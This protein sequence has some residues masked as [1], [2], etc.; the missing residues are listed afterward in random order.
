MRARREDPRT[1]RDGRKGLLTAILLALFD[2]LAIP[3]YAQDAICARVRIEIK[4]E[5][6]LE[7]QAFE[8]EMQITN[9]VDT[10]PMSEVTI[11]VLF[12]D[13]NGN[14]VKAT[15]E[16]NDPSGKALFFIRTD[17]LEG[18]QNITGTGSIG[19]GATAKIR[20]LIIPAAGSGG[21]STTG[22]LYLVGAV[23]GYKLG[24]EPKTI[25]VAPDSIFVKPLPKLALDYFLTNEVYADDPFTPAI[26]PPEPFTLGV[27]VKNNGTV[28]ARNLKIESAQPKI[29]E[30]TQGLLINFRLTGSYVNDQ[31]A[32]N[33]LLIGFG[34][35]P[36][37]RA[38][39]GRWIMITTLSGKF[40]DFSATFTH[41][42]ELGGSV[43]SLLEPPMTHLL[44][45]D[46]KVDL[47]GRDGV[48]DFL[49]RD[50]DALN[51]Y[52]SDSGDSPVIDQSGL[53]SLAQGATQ[54]A[55]TALQLNAPATQGFFYAKLKDPFSG[56]K[57][58]G[59]VVRADGKAMAPENVWLSK[60]RN[61]S[62]QWEYFVNF[63]DV[64]T[65]GRYNLVMSPRPSGPQPPVLQFLADYSVREGQ[66]VSFVVEASDPNGDQVKLSAAPLPAGAKFTDGGA[67]TG[68]FD[69]I[70][71]PGQAGKYT[72]VYEASDGTLKS[73]QSAAI[74]VQPAKPNGPDIPTLA[75]PAVDSDVRV[76]RPILVV[77]SS[78]PLDT[79]Q[80][81]TF[82]VYGDGGLS[83]LLYQADVAKAGDST[84]W[85]VPLDLTD[86]T[87]YWW[88]V[89]AFDGT[90]YSEWAV[91]RFFVNLANDPPA[92][93]QPSYPR[94]GTQVDSLTPTF[95]VSNSADPDGDAVTFGFQLYADNA[96][97]QSL[98]SVKD[99][100]AG[101]DGTTSW[102]PSAPLT[103]GRDYF[104][105]ATAT[106]VHG[107]LTETPLLKFSVNTANHA[108][109]APVVSDPPA[110]STLPGA[111][112]TL[113]VANATDADGDLLSYSLELDTTPSFNGAAKRTS[114][115]LNSGSGTTSWNVTGLSDDT[116]YY[117]RARA[118]DGKAD[119]PW[120]RGEFLVS[121]RDDPPPVPVLRNVG[122]G[123]CTDSPRPRLELAPV[124]DPEGRPVTYRFQLYGDAAL[125]ALIAEAD[126]VAPEWL[127]PVDLA[128][129]STYYWRARAKDE[130]GN[131][132]A[133]TSAAEFKVILAGVPAPSITL[134]SPAQIVEPKDGK[135]TIGWEIRDA[136][137]SSAVALYWDRTG[138]G[139][140]GSLIVDKLA[141]D[142]A[143]RAGQY[144]WDVSTFAPGVYY[145]Y[146]V[147]NNPQRMSV[148]YAA[149]I[150][151][152][153]SPAPKG[154]VL[155]KP[156]SAQTTTET[157]ATATVQVVLGSEPSADVVVGVNSSRPGEGRVN[158][159]SL[160]FTQSNWS[161]P[162]TV[163]I[164][165]VNDCIADGDQAYRIIAARAV[166]NDLNYAGVKGPDQ[167]LINLDDDAPGSSTQFAVCNIRLV[168]TKR[169]S[170]LEFDYSFLLDATNL[171]AD[172]AGLTGTL[173]VNATGTKV[174]DGNVVFGP[175]PSGATVTSQ[176]TFTIRQDR[177]YMFDPKLLQWTLT[178]VP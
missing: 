13:E 8:A 1:T 130:G 171:G 107:A 18:I 37:Q 54:G 118:S 64:N 141:Q 104:W 132:S 103:Q 75:G 56:Q 14:P 22:K 136:L 158:P 116:R 94:N 49:A 17:G 11:N 122:A 12:S 117:W 15:S 51:V 128:D 129:G 85:K 52:E 38:S 9:A 140:S 142:P 29:T 160:T 137:N 33:S 134:T 25:E 124:W 111:V 93:P 47:P 155:I 88:R 16:P 55:D 153:V 48:R 26:E 168:A 78:N 74:T 114:A 139:A 138:S 108:P 154:T 145:V 84:T 23:L 31:P 65:P 135:V 156:T 175:I 97:T 39:M 170:T 96:G 105:R 159:A 58:V 68:V 76:L 148:Q 113:T 46:V 163:V 21:A 43:T 99:L 6:T 61:S 151:V 146:A 161:V 80:R 102:T 152:I 144:V 81:Y 87:R 7:R 91:G 36:A 10:N 127:V 121:A 109:G 83:T 115:P 162:Q 125:T 123:A 20:W 143:K 95:S 24:A 86:N 174:I 50:G 59:T 79:V 3:A 2:L 119:G 164:S 157:G 165:G 63:F 89:R 28:P 44:V 110:A 147:A 149:G 150:V 167:T 172:V 45:R 35:V 34:D 120:A 70:P 42:D 30:N 173:S 72:I 100:P 66:Q 77:R 176:D 4:Q 57:V 40:V 41:S 178:P 112:V 133:W 166:S 53:A 73:S 131:T 101:A 82:E 169:A 27:R 106:D 71:M 5:L 62:N 67:G 177:R 69:W 32:T 98:A 60:T 92:P 126:G 90:L 19:P